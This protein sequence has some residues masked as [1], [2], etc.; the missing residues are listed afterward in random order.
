MKEVHRTPTMPFLDGIHV[1]IL[2]LTTYVIIITF[3][4]F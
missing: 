3:E 2:T 4:I 1:Q